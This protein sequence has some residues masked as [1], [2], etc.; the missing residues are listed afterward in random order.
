MTGRLSNICGSFAHKSSQE[1]VKHHSQESEC[2]HPFRDS[3]STAAGNS[4]LQR[5]D[6]T[7]LSNSTPPQKWCAT[8]PRVLLEME[9]SF[10][11]GGRWH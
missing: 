10:L 6:R 5:W 3:Q 4:V 8:L 1:E 9:H 2:G 7:D 11:H